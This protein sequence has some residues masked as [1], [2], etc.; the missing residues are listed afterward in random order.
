MKYI[1]TLKSFKESTAMSMGASTDNKDA[2]ILKFN[3]INSM[4]NTL[5]N[6][7]NDFSGHNT[8]QQAAEATFL[9]DKLM[10]ND[11]KK[12]FKFKKI[13]KLKNTL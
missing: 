2:S 12:K 1:K 7:T 13:K 8:Q 10:R 9:R 11:K 5:Q 6:A 3:N 4:G